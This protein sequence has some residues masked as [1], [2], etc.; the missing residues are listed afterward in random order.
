MCFKNTINSN[1]EFP[2]LKI[3]LQQK[4]K[5]YYITL[6]LIRKKMPQNES[7]VFSKAMEQE[8]LSKL[9]DNK[10]CYS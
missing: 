10:N 8:I 9:R 5:K 7:R 6:N 4:I 2:K 1:R 3:N